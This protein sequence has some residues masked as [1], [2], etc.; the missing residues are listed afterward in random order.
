MVRGASDEGSSILCQNS[1]FWRNRLHY[2]CVI[3][4]LYFLT[5]ALH[6]IGQPEGYLGE[7]DDER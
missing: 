2:I 1:L 3:V 5:C 4:T 6:H 7:D